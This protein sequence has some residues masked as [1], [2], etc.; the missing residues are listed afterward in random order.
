[1]RRAKLEI[2]KDVLEYCRHAPKRMSW[3]IQSV[4][5]NSARG[6]K[7]L[8]LCVKRGFLQ[9]VPMKNYLRKGYLTTENG[10]EFIKKYDELAA[11]LQETIRAI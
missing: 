2:V 11:I 8:G 3:V 1:M 4:H 5:L 10:R 9:E 7:I 6:Q